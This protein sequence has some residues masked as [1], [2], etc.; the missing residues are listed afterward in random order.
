MVKAR[1]ARGSLIALFLISLVLIPSFALSED[2]DDHWGSFRGNS[3][4]QGVGNSD[5]EDLSLWWDFKADSPIGTTVIVKDKQAIFGTDNGTV[6]S[7]T[8][9]LGEVEWTVNVGSGIFSTPAMDPE[10]GVVYVCDNSGKVTSIYLENGTIKWQ[11]ISPTGMA[12]QSSPLVYDGKIYF[13]SDDAYLYCIYQNG[14]FAWRYEGCTG[15]IY[16]SPSNYLDLIFFGSCDGK[17]RGISASNGIEQ[18]NYTTQ[19]IPSSPAIK[20]GKVFFGDYDSKLNCL[21]ALT[22][23]VIWNTTM[24]DDVYSSPSVTDEKIVVGCNDGSLYS[25][26]TLTGEILWTLDLGPSS[27]ETSPVISNE[28]VAV[29]YGQ[30][31]VI[32]H[33][34]NGT[35]HRKY[36]YGDSRDLSPSVYKGKVFFGD[37]QGY[38]YCLQKGTPPGPDDD[39][40]HRNPSIELTVGR[41]ATYFVIAIILVGSLIIFIYLRRKKQ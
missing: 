41:G 39:G 40:G 16:T 14:T 30:G 28:M 24:G 4:N 38:V 31:L 10:L 35:I 36:L 32:V 21:D 19:Y 20:D 23:E 17:M 2:S 15:W 29:T 11:W 1:W 37:S 12:I 27:L 18:W 25:L 34:S 26:D 13:G 7:L 8:S 6:Y 22:G 3:Y 9:D 33:L 5:I